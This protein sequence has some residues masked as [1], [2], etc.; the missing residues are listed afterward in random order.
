MT[1]LS[2]PRWVGIDI[3]KATLDVCLLPEETMFQV[4]NDAAGWAALL[5]RL[6]ADDPVTIVLEATGSYHRGVTLALTGAGHPP[7]VINPQR[8]HAFMV[9]EGVRSK[10]DRSDARLLARFGQQKGP[11]PSPVLSENARI[12][13]DLVGCRDDLTKSLVMEKNRLGVASAA[14]R[15]VHE[16]TIAFLTGQIARVDARIA[17][18]I[19]A[20]ADLTARGAV[21]RSAPGIGP[22]LSAVLL[23]RLPELGTTAPKALAA[24]AGVAPY[25]RDSGTK[26]GARTIG[27]G[28]P[29]V[30]KALFQMART[31]VRCDPTMGAHYRQLRG[32]MPDKAALIAC[33]RRMVGILNA[34]LR[35]GL[36]WQDTDVGRGHFLPDPA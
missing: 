17:D 26:R 4:A 13:T 14:V 19:A 1:T 22:V 28:R 7:A 16:T 20:D 11:A 34:M 33:A 21:L 29:A 3:A 31:A 24:L 5:A 23:A 2:D 25:A 35:E 27:G 36:T 12:L 6:P 15:D 18:L 30:C 8:T 32:R 10:T 9:S